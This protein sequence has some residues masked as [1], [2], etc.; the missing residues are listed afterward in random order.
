MN[1]KSFL[2]CACLL[3]TSM[4]W[5]KVKVTGNGQIT[6]REFE[7][8]DYNRLSIN[9]F[10]DVIYEQSDS[11]PYLEITLDDNLMPFVD[12]QIKDRL[13]TI[14]FKGVTVEKVTTGVIKTNSKWLRE[15]KIAGNA[16]FSIATPMK[17][18][19]LIIKG[20]DNSLIQ[21]KES[22]ELGKLDLNISGSAN[23]IA[24]NLEVEN[25]ACNIAGSG[26][27][28]LNKGHAKYAIYN[29]RN[30]GLIQAYGVEAD[31][32]IGKVTAGGT[33]E[34]FAKEKLS[35]NTVGNAIIRY[36][37]NPHT[38]QNKKVGKG[39]VDHVE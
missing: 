27:M 12:V 32:V 21:L 4:T 39:T 6:T 16:G 25:L 9:G 35:T 7:I 34:I 3:M 18:D 14:R 33:M 36:K 26:T 11:D 2:L 15:A 10:F 19:E 37:G 29:I 20:H 28:K 30:N 31:E 22:L 17:G 24:E 23:I 38:L 13:L 1:T 5:A 8:I